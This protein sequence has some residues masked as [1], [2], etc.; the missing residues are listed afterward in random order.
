MSKQ[1]DF[2]AQFRIEPEI[3]HQ[4]LLNKIIGLQNAVIQLQ[5][6]V[7]E[8]RQRQIDFDDRSDPIMRAPN[9]PS[10]TWKD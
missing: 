9:S 10:F 6:I 2:T 1:P 3:E 8:M 7:F 4:F 5:G